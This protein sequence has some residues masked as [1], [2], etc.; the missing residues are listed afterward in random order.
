MQA[1]C[2][3]T[4]VSVFL[5]ELACILVA[6]SKRVDKQWPTLI[7][8]D[9]TLQVRIGSFSLP[10]LS[11]KSS[12]TSI[13]MCAQAPRVWT[14][15]A[16]SSS[17]AGGMWMKSSWFLCKTIHSSRK[18]NI[19]HFILQENQLLIQ[20]LQDKLPCPC[21]PLQLLIQVTAFESFCTP[22][23]SKRLG[24]FTHNH[25]SAYAHLGFE[26]YNFAGQKHTL[27]QLGWASSQST[28][29]N[30]LVDSSAPRCK[31]SLLQE[32][33]YSCPAQLVPLLFCLHWQTWYLLWRVKG[34]WHSWAPSLSSAGP[35]LSPRAYSTKRTARCI[36][37]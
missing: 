27:T 24:C 6:Q 30:L 34:R 23:C 5:S 31:C 28:C 37:K 13:L 15:K 29:Y 18:F 19:Q 33:R 3:T 11:V 10:I 17:S 14:G 12:C 36:L 9:I 7:Q 20:E 25:L 1:Q 26:R 16:D 4:V 22:V 2:H 35:A 32:L 8:L 21:N